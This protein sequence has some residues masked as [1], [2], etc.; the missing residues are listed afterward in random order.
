[1]ISKCLIIFQLKFYVEWSSWGA[2]DVAECNWMS[3]C[4]SSQQ[5]GC[6]DKGAVVSV[7]TCEAIFPEDKSM[8]T[9]AENAY[10]CVISYQTTSLGISKKYYT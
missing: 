8:Q 2:C 4:I 3:E 6:E 7:E 1:M 9:C 5:R 10:A